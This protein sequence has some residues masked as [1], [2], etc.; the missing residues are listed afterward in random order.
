MQGYDTK[1]S[2]S[3]CECGHR[4]EEHRGIAECVIPGCNC[5][6]FHLINAE[7]THEHK[8]EVCGRTYT[9]SHNRCTETDVTGICNICSKDIEDNYRGDTMPYLFGIT[10]DKPIY[11][12][13]AKRLANEILKSGV[14][15]QRLW[16]LY[17]GG[18]EE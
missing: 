12:L 14:N 16:D 6:Q 5:H 15:I 2:G 10:S 8:C 18:Y 17:K 11:L 13:R 7:K 4:F 1:Y 3:S 9:C